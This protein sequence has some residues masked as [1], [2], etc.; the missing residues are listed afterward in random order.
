MV[1]I[2]AY[3][4]SAI[5]WCL[6][7]KQLRTRSS[8]M[9]T[10]FLADFHDRKPKHRARI[11]QLCVSWSWEVEAWTIHLWNCCACQ[12][13]SPFLFGSNREIEWNW[14]KW[15]LSRDGES[16]RFNFFHESPSSLLVA[17]HTKLWQFLKWI[18][19]GS[20]FPCSTLAVSRAKITVVNHICFGGHP[21][22]SKLCSRKGTGS[23]EH[24]QRIF[25]SEEYLYLG[26]SDD[27]GR[28]SYNWEMVECNNCR[29]KMA[30]ARLHQH[31]KRGS[32]GRSP[33][34]FLHS[35]KLMECQRVCVLWRVA[36]DP[37]SRMLVP[38][39]HTHGLATG[40]WLW[41]VLL[42]DLK[43]INGLW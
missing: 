9:V 22:E 24:G 5:G 23:V 37:N 32:R 28:Y 31:W 20:A 21:I 19:L 40:T 18:P 14:D 16:W 12:C 2:H 11:T 35:S 4:I 1:N 33:F 42:K 6:G 25:A 27:Q 8:E 10:R 13:M 34:W 41:N 39:L 7:L 43:D 26:R 15:L 30:K 17:M 36:V 38:L 29:K 3:S